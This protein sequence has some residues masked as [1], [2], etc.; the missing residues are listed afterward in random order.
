MEVKSKVDINLELKVKRAAKNRNLQ[1]DEMFV[2]KAC[3]FQDLLD[4]RHSVM[5]LGPAG[6]VKTTIWQ[7]LQE[8]LNLES[9][10]HVCICETVNRKAVTC[11]EVYGSMSL[12]KEWRDGVLSII[13]R[14]MSKNDAGLHY[15]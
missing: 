10:K 9:E 12:S 4:V 2:T 3:N 1:Q 5:L 11:D 15:H 8:A 13:M 6:S 7:T 14:G